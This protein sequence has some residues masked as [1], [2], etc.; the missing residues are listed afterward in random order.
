MNRLFVLTFENENDR[1]S[2]SKYYIPKVE[3]GHFNMLFNGKPSFEIPVG[4]REEGYE[5]IIEM[6]KNND[7]TTV[8]LLDYEYFKDH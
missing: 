6:N 5:A 3:V 8:K 7:Y 4:N 2:F 1:T